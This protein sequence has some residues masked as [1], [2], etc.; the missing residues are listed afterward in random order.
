MESNF[1]KD[2]LDFQQIVLMHIKKILEIST[3]EL[4]SGTQI[5]N[6]G[7]YTQTSI[8]EDT[9]YSY[10]Q[11]IE[12]LAYIL[13][14]YFDKEIRK[15]YDPCIK[16]MNGFDYEVKGIIKEIYYKVC[17]DTGKEDLGRAFI[18]EMRLKY[19]KELFV[20]LNEL[21]HRNNYLKTA[22]FGE[23]NDEISEGDLEDDN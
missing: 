7:N 13:L 17:E 2:K 8:Q 20:G 9:R 21:L 19:A 6:A 12:N 3:H 14:P 15:I 1:G 5:V 16:I 4:R 11:S 23:D 22:V 10:I 18:L